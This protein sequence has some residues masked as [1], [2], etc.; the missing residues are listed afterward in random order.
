MRT[1][2]APPLSIIDPHTRAPRAG[3]Y[4]G[5]LPLCDLSPL[6]KSRIFRL[7][8]RKRWFFATIA[9]DDLLLAVAVVHIGYALKSFV[10]AFDRAASAIVVD[11]S[12]IGPTALG[13]ISDDTGE[14]FA[15]R[16]HLPLKDARIEI[17]RPV[18]AGAYLVRVSVPDLVIDASLRTAN[19]PPPLAVIAPLEGPE[20]GLLDATEKRALMTVSGEATVAGRRYALDGALAGSDYTQ[21]Y[22][23]RRTAWRWAFVLGCATNGERV[24]LNLTQGF[25]GELECAAWIDHELIPLSGASIDLDPQNPNHPMR[26]RTLDGALDLRFD[27]GGAHFEH[28]DFRIITARFL[29]APGSATGTLALPGHTTLH[30]D[31]AL[32]IVEDQDVLW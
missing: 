5:E 12:Y 8:H 13:S 20:A 14:G 31:R 11:R 32:G 1:L 23:P 16:F 18:G 7:T 17:T 25:V 4:R 3:A 15:A 28:D 24:G 10:F 6:G 30:L 22:L 2:T 19:A 9:A 21:G 27:P 29:Q 26:I